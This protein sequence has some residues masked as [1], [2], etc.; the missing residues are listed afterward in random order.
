MTTFGWMGEG[1]WG[2]IPT[3]NQYKKNPENETLDNRQTGRGD[4][5]RLEKCDKNVQHASPHHM[6]PPSI[7]GC[8]GKDCGMRMAVYVRVR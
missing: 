1:G 4:Y 7:P 5:R 8:T 3:Y 6:S 2:G